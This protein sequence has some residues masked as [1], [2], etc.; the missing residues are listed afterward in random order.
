MLEA[1]RQVA[2]WIIPPL[3]EAHD[4]QYGWRVRIALTAF[5]TF[6]G[7]CLVTAFAFGMIPHVPGFARAGDLE[8]QIGLVKT[9][10]AGVQLEVSNNVG[11]VQRQLQA[12]EA[13]RIEGELLQLRLQHCAAKKQSKE[14]LWQRIA[15]L[16]VKYQQL[17]GRVYPLP[18]C[19]DL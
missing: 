15:A 11:S 16:L 5:V 3:D 9:Q 19:T 17:T 2:E 4:K 18:G 12:D 8:A 1:V 6:L 7:L 13:E 10:I 14:L